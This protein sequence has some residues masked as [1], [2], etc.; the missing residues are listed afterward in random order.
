MRKKPI[1][2]VLRREPYYHKL[3]YSKTPKFDTA[4]AVFGVTV[5]AFVVYLTLAT[6]GST[7]ADLSDLTILVWYL[8]IFFQSVKTFFS[9]QKK[10]ITRHHGFFGI[11][12]FFF[13]EL[14]GSFLTYLR[15]FKAK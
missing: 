14:I 10:N 6:V 4:A 8:F 3:Q 2:F 7:G 9:L 12:I 5:G 15:R 11:F 13:K 1:W